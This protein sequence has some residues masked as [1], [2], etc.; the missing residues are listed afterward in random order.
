MN[1]KT[2]NPESIPFSGH[3]Q[4][5]VFARPP[6]PGKVKTRLAREVGDDKAAQI[7]RELLDHAF[8]MIESLP[9]DI[10][11][12]I[13]WDNSNNN[14]AE[15]TKH[16]RWIQPSGNLGEKMSW[17]ISHS[18]E[19]GAGKAMIIGTDCP[20]ITLSTITDAFQTLD[21]AEVVLGPAEDG[22]YYLVG[23]KQV[24]P[25]LFPDLQW[26]T[27]LVLQETIKSLE[28]AGISYSL[29]DLKY[30]IDTWDDWKRWQQTIKNR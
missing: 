19:K 14:R 29:L 7:Y 3:N 15:Y 4:L 8:Q 6:V 1:N 21:N 25:A 10:K 23:A 16:H 27:N 11:C 12:A 18:I 5:V 13:A 26:G 24:I 20:T 17:A 2:L 28:N 30:D 22:G 9:K